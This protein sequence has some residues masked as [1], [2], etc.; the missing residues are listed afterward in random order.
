VGSLFLQG[1]EDA[2]MPVADDIVGEVIWPSALLRMS[3]DYFFTAERLAREVGVNIR[4]AEAIVEVLLQEGMIQPWFAPQCPNCDEIWAAYLGE[5]D[6]PESI[7]CPFCGE[8]TP[9][10]L[11]EF[12]L[13]YERL[14]TRLD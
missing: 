9:E 14:K 3:G 7:H 4:Q 11:V 1:T 6:I 12:Y 10:H 2:E 8:G 13:V 5:D